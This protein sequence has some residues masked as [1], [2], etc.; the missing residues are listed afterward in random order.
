MEHMALKADRRSASGTKHARR[1]RAAGSMPVIIYGH[2]EPPESV[3]LNTHDVLLELQHS[4]HTLELELDGKRS[5]YLVKD[6]QYD[7]L[8]THPIHLDLMRVDASERV[9]V[10]VAVELRATPVGVAEGGVLDHPTNEIEVECLVIEIPD[11]II[12][13]VKHLGVGDALLAKDLD[14]PQGV[15]LVSEPEE[16]IAAVRMLAEEAPVEEEAEVEPG[17]PEVIGRPQEGTESEG[18]D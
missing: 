7:Y 17:Q 16:R 11:T 15:D 4:A 14:L 9:R 3:S 1:V 10:K 5:R 12:A 2:G 13:S 6:V 8:G 18:Q